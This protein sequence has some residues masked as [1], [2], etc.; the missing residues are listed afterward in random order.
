MGISSGQ[1]LR[2]KTEMRIFRN[3][4]SYFDQ[5]QQ[6]QASPQ[7]TG[8]SVMHSE[9]ALVISHNDLQKTDCAELATS[10]TQGGVSGVA[11]AHALLKTSVPKAPMQQRLFGRPVSAGQEGCWDDA[12]RASALSKKIK[13]GRAAAKPLQGNSIAACFQKQGAQ[14]A[15]VSAA[16]VS[17]TAATLYI[18]NGIFQ[19]FEYMGRSY[20]TYNDLLP[21]PY[22]P[23]FSEDVYLSVWLHGR[24]ARSVRVS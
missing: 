23:S 4:C 24:Q 22:T 16:V 9:A 14:K 6:P 1:V 7:H 10:L 21:V 20:K 15:I 8:C 12:A 17:R 18:E 5:L 2:F 13:L 19:P 11:L 3:L